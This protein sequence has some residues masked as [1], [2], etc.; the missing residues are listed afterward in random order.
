[1]GAARGV[2]I[3]MRALTLAI[4]TVAL[5]VTSVDPSLAR[6]DTAMGVT[7]TMVNK[8]LQ[9]MANKSAPVQQRRRQLRESIENE[10]DFTEMS[11]SALGYH[12]RTITPNQ[13]AQF[14][15]LFTAFI[16]DAYLSK[17]QDYSGQ[18]VQFQGQSPLGQGYS[19]VNTAIVQSGKS[20]I[21][22]NYLLL[23]KDQTWKI[24]D[25]TVDAI[26]IIAN[27]RNQFNRVI[28]D[29]GFDQLMADLQ[30]KQQ[31]LAALLGN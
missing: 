26:S 16:E 21:T 31:E 3:R 2:A 1:L 12:W 9:I 22:V 10:F 19:Q 25:V 24:Y 6:A 14:T 15:K 27:Y 23:Q 4:A 29:K 28:N 17:I 30:A 7:Q 20:P 13:R 8:A 18:Q 11:K 5:I